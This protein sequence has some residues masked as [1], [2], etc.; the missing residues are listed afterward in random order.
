MPQVMNMAPWK[1][2]REDVE[3]AKVGLFIKFSGCSCFCCHCEDW[4]IFKL[5]PY[6][7][8]KDG[9]GY[10]LDRAALDREK[11]RFIKKYGGFAE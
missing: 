11:L 8:T 4:K 6:E 5:K 9:S 7:L 2:T 10:I 3:S 1:I